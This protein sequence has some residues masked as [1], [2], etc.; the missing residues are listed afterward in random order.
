ME[1]RHATYVLSTKVTWFRNAEA[2]IDSGINVIHSPKHQRNRYVKYSCLLPENI[3]IEMKASVIWHELSCF[4]LILHFLIIISTCISTN[5]NQSKQQASETKPRTL[6][7]NINH[8]SLKHITL[9]NMWPCDHLMVTFPS[10]Q[11]FKGPFIRPGEKQTQ[12]GDSNKLD[13][14]QCNWTASVMLVIV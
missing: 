12:V 1:R 4:I 13:F 9:Q 7:L 8:V 2:C 11:T 5:I 10:L 6:I 14:I 3:T